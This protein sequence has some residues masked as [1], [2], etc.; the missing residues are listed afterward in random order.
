MLKFDCLGEPTNDLERS[1]RL[2][3][4]DLQRGWPGAVI[5]ASHDREL[6]DDMNV[7]VELTP[8]GAVRYGGHYSAFRER[9]EREVA[10]Q[11]LAHAE[12][13]QAETAERKVRTV[14]AG[15]MSRAKG[16]QP[17]ILVEAARAVRKSPA[18]LA[19]LRGCGSIFA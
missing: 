16:D 10:A 4:I 9:K 11:D 5:V 12:K 2:A 15:R 6:L 1:G 3:V 18:E 7:M 14:N 13:A 8:L 17:T 19:F